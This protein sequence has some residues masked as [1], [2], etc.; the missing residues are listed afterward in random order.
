MVEQ[1]SHNELPQADG[2]KF[3]LSAVNNFDIE[4]ARTRQ[5]QKLMALLDER[6]KQTQTI[7]LNEVKRRLGLNS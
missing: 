3:A 1:P 2:N 5:N 7:L 6:A 4:I